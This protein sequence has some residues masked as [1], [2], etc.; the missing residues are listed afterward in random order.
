MGLSGLVTEGLE[1]RAWKVS[2]Q[3][4]FV[5]CPDC[6]RKQW[7]RSGRTPEL[8]RGFPLGSGARTVLLSNICYFRCWKGEEP[9]RFFPS[10]SQQDPCAAPVTAIETDYTCDLLIRRASLSRPVTS[11]SPPYAFPDFSILSLLF[12]VTN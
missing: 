1:I 4:G 9:A 10:Q 11:D 3:L 12:N 8:R 6:F 2:L 5:S 7:S